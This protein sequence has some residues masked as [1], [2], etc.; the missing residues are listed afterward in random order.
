MHTHTTAALQ[1]LA[2]PHHYELHILCRLEPEPLRL[3]RVRVRDRV[4][5]YQDVLDDCM[6]RVK[7][8]DDMAQPG[9]AWEEG[10]G[11]GRGLGGVRVTLRSGGLPQP[12][13]DGCHTPLASRGYPPGLQEP[14][15]GGGASTH[16]SGG[17]NVCRLGPSISPRCM[18][19]LASPRS[20]S[21]SRS[22]IS[23]S[24][25]RSIASSAAAGSPAASSS[26]P[27]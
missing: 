9:G 19:R 20:T 8:R 24:R 4:T 18:A 13:I 21:A 5:L 3:G 6:L 7:Q 16:T 22:S 12:M 10:Y 14:G 26:V 25:A 23:T 27:G 2:T 11:R 15:S 1:L 17:A